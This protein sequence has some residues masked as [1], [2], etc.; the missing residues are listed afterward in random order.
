MKTDRRVAAMLEIAEALCGKTEYSEVLAGALEAALRTAGAEAGSILLHSA[1]DDA[2]VFEYVEGPVAD[3]LTGRQLSTSHGIAGQVFR[4]GV[5]ILSN[6][7]PKEQYHFS[8]VP[9]QIGYPSLTMITVPLTTLGGR[10]LGVLQAINKRDGEFTHDDLELLTIVA[11]QV[12]TII[13]N[14][15]L[16]EAARLGTA[17][18]VLADIGHD[19]KNMIAPVIASAAA[20]Q[21]ILEQH[22]ALLDET[23]KQPG[24]RERTVEQLAQRAAESRARCFE[25]VA[26]VERTAVRVRER[27]LQMADCIKGKVLPPRLQPTHVPDLAREVAGTLGPWAEKRGIALEFEQMGACPAIQG[28]SSHL[29]SAVYNLALN[30]IQ[31]TPRGG[32]VTV[33]VHTVLDGD[34]P[35]GACLKIEVTDTGKG[36]PPEVLGKLFTTDLVTTKPDGIGLG[37]R[38]VREVAEMHG[39]AV[40]VAS[41]LGSGTCFTLT[42]PVSQGAGIREVKGASRDAP[43]PPVGADLRKLAAVDFPPRSL[44]PPWA[45]ESAPAH[46]AEPPSERDGSARGAQLYA[47]A[48]SW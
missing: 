41:E 18:Q 29:F 44:G 20:L 9:E 28:D 23:I 39:G 35:G 22:F 34:L 15:R 2:L 17:A 27:T 19:V 12:A 42:L 11:A 7:V 45:P 25:V 32:R 48:S 38:I 10:R 16:H 33:R 3:Q 14:A 37:T 47:A 30:A 21:A 4:T 36:I 5:P 46:V 31:E 26:L 6:D 43:P 1:D 40:S 13:E 24:D 8:R